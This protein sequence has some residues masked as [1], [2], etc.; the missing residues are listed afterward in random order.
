M[1]SSLCNIPAMEDYLIGFVFLS[2]SINSLRKRTLP[3]WGFLSVFPSGL[4]PSCANSLKSRKDLSDAGRKW[5]GRHGLTPLWLGDPGILF[6]WLK[7]WLRTEIKRGT[8][9]KSRVWNGTVRQEPKQEQKIPK[10]SP[11]LTPVLHMMYLTYDPHSV[12]HQSL[13]MATPH[14]RSWKSSSASAPAPPG[15]WDFCFSFLD[16]FS[17]TL[18]LL[19]LVSH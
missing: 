13:P 19:G 4:A 18:P 1:A 12:C 17:T 9:W 6:G 7:Q 14:G 5:R 10:A 16:G 8:K 2:E 15:S 11:L 3:P